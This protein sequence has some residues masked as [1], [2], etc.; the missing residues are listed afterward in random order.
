[1]YI[2]TE[3]T[4]RPER[5]SPIA[6]RYDIQTE[7]VMEN[8]MHA[9]AY[10]CD[11]LEELLRDAS[12]IFAEAEETGGAFRVLVIDSIIAL[13]R[14]VHAPSDA[15]PPSSA[16]WQTP[17]RAHSTDGWRGARRSSS[18][19]ASSLSGSSALAR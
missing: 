12:G 5:L 7:F 1:M 6:T 17:E 9:R 15:Q 4:F 11:M 19:A 13:Y 14:Q 2:D 8:V 16:T 3:G 10:N 18:A